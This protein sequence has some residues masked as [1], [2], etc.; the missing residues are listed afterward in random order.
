VLTIDDIEAAAERIAPAAAKTPFFEPPTLSERLGVR[1]FLKLENMQPTGSFKIRGAYNHVSARREEAAKGGVLAWSSGNHGQAVARSARLMGLKA[2]IVMPQDTPRTKVAGVERDGAEIVFYDRRTENR[3]EIGGA[4]AE[5]RGAIIV[6]PYDH[7]LTIAGQGTT[8]LEIA[9][10]AER[11]GVSLEAVLVCCGGGGLAA[12]C[13]T[14][15]ADRMPGCGVYTVEPEGYDDTARSLRSGVRETADTSR[16]SICDALM[17]PTPGEIT[18]AINRDRVAGGFA[19]TDDEV[20]EAVRYAA[21]ELHVVVEPG[22]AVALAAL[23]T[24]RY[25]PKGGAVAAV[26]SGGNIDPDLLGE[27]LTG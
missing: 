14:A 6:P 4:I 26:V 21:R 19:V 17:A 13:A 3:E 8:G 23:L 16:H 9:S 5:E 20:R 24:G 11:L 7:L 10:E 25:A 15:L 27:I 1:A 18:F 22:G 12:G 2:T